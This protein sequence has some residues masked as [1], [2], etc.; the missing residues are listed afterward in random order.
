MERVIQRGVVVLGAMLSAVSLAQGPT[1]GLAQDEFPKPRA[2]QPLEPKTIRH[3]IHEGV[4]EY[5]F[6]LVPGAEAEGKAPSVER[7]DVRRVGDPSVLETLKPSV[8]EL[9]DGE[10]PGLEVQDVNFDAYADLRLQTSEQDCEYWVF[11]PKTGR[12]S[13]LDVGDLPCL[14][15]DPVHKKLSFHFTLSADEYLEEAYKFVGGKLTLVRSER[16]DYDG[17]SRA[18]VV[19]IVEELKNGQMVVTSKKTLSASKDD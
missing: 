6:T 16:Q 5:E 13:F 14:T 19:R 1:P 9:R 12:F 17:D 10:I 18:R 15:V 4:P 7:I 2:S 11:E 8:S 3:A